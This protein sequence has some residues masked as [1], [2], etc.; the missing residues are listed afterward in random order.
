MTN[1][2]AG[3]IEFEHVEAIDSLALAHQKCKEC[4]K[5]ILV[6]L[7]APHPREDKSTG[8]V[9]YRW[10]GW[11]GMAQRFVGWIC[12]EC[13]WQRAEET[14]DGPKGAI[15]GPNSEFTYD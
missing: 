13:A 14:G 9:A 1:Y 3:K 11:D 5:D 7:W 10:T 2:G 12:D 6:V 4:E 15:A 8:M